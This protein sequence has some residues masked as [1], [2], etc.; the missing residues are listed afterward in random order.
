MRAPAVL[1]L[2]LGLVPLAAPAAVLRSGEHPGFTRIVL[3]GLPGP[4]WTLG[5]TGTGYALRLGLSAKAIDL[6]GAFRTIGRQRITGISATEDGALRID[7]GCAC[8][9]DPFRTESGL[10]VIDIRDGAAPEHSPWEAPLPGI[11]IA[12]PASDAARTFAPTVPPWPLRR[13]DP[14][15]LARWRHLYGRPGTAEVAT[16][17]RIGP[18]AEDGV[19]S[20]GPE[21]LAAGDDG[22]AGPAA[23]APL[24]P[25]ARAEVGANLRRLLDRAATQGLV[26]VAKDALRA[27]ERPDRTVGDPAAGWPGLRGET[28]ADRDAPPAGAGGTGIA[29]ADACPPSEALDPRGWRGEE[30]PGRLIGALRSAAL[31]EFDRPDPDRVLAFARGL[32]ALAMG[33]EA[34]LVLRSFA[35]AG[36]E[37]ALLDEVARLVDQRPPAEGG[38]LRTLTAC[39][40]YT[41]FWAFLAAGSDV[42]RRT[43]PGPV[44][45]SFAGLGRELRMALGAGLAGAFLDIDDP[46]SARVIDNALLGADPEASD[47]TRARI[48]LA[49]GRP[50]EALARLDRLALSPGPDAVEAL[51][52]AIERRLA[53]GEPVPPRQVSAAGG[54]LVELRGQPIRP[55][56]LS[57]YILGLASL[58]DFAAAVAAY[59]DAAPSLSAD[60]ADAVLSG[61]YADLAE[62]ADDATFLRMLERTAAFRQDRDLSP[63][64]RLAVARRLADLGLLAGAEDAAGP[65][66]DTEEG[67]ALAARLALGRGDPAAALARIEGLE[68]PEI[69]PLRAEALARLGRHGEAAPRL[70]TLG[71][72][73]AAGREAWLSGDPDLVSRLGGAARVADLSVLAPAADAGTAPADPAVL[74]GA[75]AALERS[76]ALRAAVGRV[77]PDEAAV[78]NPS[79][80]PGP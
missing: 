47:L 1:G 57:A 49:G 73:A 79:S 23:E 20:A 12:S 41:G 9:A 65:A 11:P 17:P 5:R 2:I 6:S 36:D 71:R 46:A 52:L 55:R 10:L 69:D 67:A 54:Y 22:P 25:T 42:R 48:E 53:A 29:L 14:P 56:V 4:E 31:G 40:G 39:E 44:L 24:V 63:H 35:V 70:A 30:P 60:R 50:E 64:A 33:D 72:E 77:L 38:R 78:A 58:G 68:S 7:L 37:A 19:V 15:D 18:R 74:S 66:L 32:V 62:A 28:A 34:R 76:R 59:G 27:T 75:R 80:S 26:E 21:P 13:S 51:V 43:A 3:D 45:L 8:H 61:L 16:E